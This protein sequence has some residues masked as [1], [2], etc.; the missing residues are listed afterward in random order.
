MKNSNAVILSKGI[1]WLHSTTAKMT[2]DSNSFLRLLFLAFQIK[3][4]EH[5]P[6]LE[7]LKLRKHYTLLALDLR[8]QSYIRVKR[9]CLLKKTALNM[10]VLNTAFG[11]KHFQRYFLLNWTK[12]RLVLQVQIRINSRTKCYSIILLRGAASYGV[13]FVSAAITSNQWRALFGFWYD[14][15]FLPGFCPIEL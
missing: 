7:S 6:F 9:V 2:T 1:T 10:L 12:F 8:G 4:C 13:R 5:T 15:E 11:F 14:I 3:L